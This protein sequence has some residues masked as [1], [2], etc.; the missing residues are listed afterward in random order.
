M[1]GGKKWWGE[2]NQEGVGEKGVPQG[3]SETLHQRPPESLDLSRI[4][5]KR[6]F[7]IYP[8]KEGN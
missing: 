2:R 8:E 1:V 7:D 3:P 6:T 5:L 4:E